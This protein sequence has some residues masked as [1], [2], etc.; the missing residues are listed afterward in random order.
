MIFSR[1]WGQRSRSGSDGHVNLVNAIAYE[2]LKGF[3]RKLTQILPTPDHQLVRFQRLWDQRSRSQSDGH[4][5][6]LN[7]LALEP[8]PL[9]E[10]EPKITQIVSTLGPRAELI[11]FWKSRVQWSDSQKRLPANSYQSTARRRKPSTKWRQNS[12][13]YNYGISYQNLISS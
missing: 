10:F 8:K 3:T 6:I 11:T 4:R 12:N 5:N 7:T 1:S 9:K 2:L 13:H